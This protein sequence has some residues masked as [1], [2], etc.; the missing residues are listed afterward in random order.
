MTDQSKI[1]LP[2]QGYYREALDRVAVRDKAGQTD[3][4]G[5]AARLSRM[6]PD[7]MQPVERLAAEGLRLARISAQAMP[8]AEMEAASAAP[9]RGVMALEPNWTVLPGGTRKREGAHWRTAGPLEAMVEQAK[10]RHDAKGKDEDAFTA[11]FTPGQVAVSE[12]Y[13]ALVEQRAAGLV[14]CSST[15]AG[16]SG[17]GTGG[18][19]ID[20][21]IQGG[22][23]LAEL[24]RRIGDGVTMQ[25]RRHLDRDNARRAI[26]VRRLVD[27]VLLECKTLTDV[28][29]AHGWQPKGETRKML[30][31]ELCAALDRM[32]GYKEH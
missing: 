17:S 16:R 8:P 5:T 21:Y 4:T 30:R 29:Y 7:K 22:R 13:R 31:L 25:V 1:T 24:H 12:D 20:S 19:A 18:L 9:A 14:K 10:Q 2:G 15:E 27:M 32:Q 28:L 6:D 23:W 26:P 11:P 3:L